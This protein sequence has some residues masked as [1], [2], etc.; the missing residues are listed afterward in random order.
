MLIRLHHLSAVMPA[1]VAGIH[2]IL[3]APQQAR[4]GWSDKL[5]HDSREPLKY[6]WN[7]LYSGEGPRIRRAPRCSV[8]YSQIHVRATTTR[9][10]TPIRKKMWAALQNAQAMKPVRRRRPNETTARLRP[11]VARSP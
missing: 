7:A 10:R 2:V 3:V 1:L 4:R 5:G 8:R 11:I 6:E 9:F